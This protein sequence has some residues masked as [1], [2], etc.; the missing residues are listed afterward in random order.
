MILQYPNEHLTTPSKDFDIDEVEEIK[1][2]FVALKE[3]FKKLDPKKCVGLAAPQIGINRNAAIVMGNP[4][5]NL[6]FT[7]ALQVET[8]KEGCFSINEASEFY[9]V[10]RPKYGWA[11]WVNPETLAG[12]EKKLTGLSAR[13]FQ[14]E[15]DHIKGRLCHDDN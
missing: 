5:F 7:P 8:D 2:T 11:R 9:N 15:L 10:R 12:V 14:H 4:M 1:A 13:V 3:E 6:E